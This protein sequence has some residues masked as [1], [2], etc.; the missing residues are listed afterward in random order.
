MTIGCTV[1]VANIYYCQ[2]L[3]GALARSFGVGQD[4]A[5][6]I[7]ILTQAGYGL[8][9]FFLVPLGDKVPRK[10]LIIIMHLLA[11]FSLVMA[12]IAP[13]INFLLIASLLVGIVSTACQVL[14]PFA[15]HLARDEERGNVVGTLL[16]GLLVGI[17]LSRTLSGFVAEYFGWRTVYWVAAGMMLVMVILF[18]V[19][20]PD[21]QPSFTGTY[22]ELMN[23]L[24]KLLKSQPV[25]RESSLI[26]AS[27][28][29]AV[30]AFWATLAFFLEGSPYHYSLSVIGMFGLI[31]AGGAMAAPLI[32][33]M[34]DRKDPL[35]PIRIGIT[36]LMLGYV[37]LLAGKWN[38]AI[39][40]AGVILLDI[41]LQGAHVPN[42]ARNYRLMPEARTRLNTIYMT[43]FFVGGTLGSCIGSLAWNSYAWKGVCIAGLIMAAL[44][45]LA[46][47]KS[48]QKLNNKYA[49]LDH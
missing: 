39:V 11:A 41:G 43:S 35:I 5:S 10:K 9:L 26:G 25:I 47:F 20:L 4:K 42:L 29:G 16:G 2:P 48:K 23:S 17:L 13:T 30:S 12:A 40:I 45:W 21:E 6:L 22:S 33:R 46:L 8:G 37:I 1:V 19:F 18:L 3:L 38:I 15:A 31:G 44:S 34:T 24:W 27:L 7:N 28:F 49:N 32:G 14:I 36:L